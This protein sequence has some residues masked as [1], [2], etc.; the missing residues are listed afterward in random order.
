MAITGVGRERLGLGTGFSGGEAGKLTSNVRLL[1][2]SFVALVLDLLEVSRDWVSRVSMRFYCLLE[3]VLELLPQ[4]ALKC[5]LQIYIAAPHLFLAHYDKNLVVGD[6]P[7]SEKLIRTRLMIWSETLRSQKQFFN[8]RPFRML[9][10]C[11]CEKVFAVFHGTP[12]P[13][14][15][16]LSPPILLATFLQHLEDR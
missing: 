13:S 14:H 2:D 3:T 5:L 7:S 1:R 8:S 11:L 12:S 10:L 16:L 4:D 9:Y 6:E 15:S